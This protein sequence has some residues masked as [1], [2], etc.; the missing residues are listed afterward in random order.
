VFNEWS[1][2]FDASWEIDVWG[3]VRRGIQAAGAN[4]V[5][6]HRAP[7]NRI[8][9]LEGR[10]QLAGGEY[11][12]IDSP[13]RQLAD[14][15]GEPICRS[16]ESGKIRR[17]G[18]DHAPA[19]RLAR[20]LTGRR[21]AGWRAGRNRAQSAIEKPSSLHCVVPFDRWYSF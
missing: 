13:V 19:V 5:H 7:G 21:F 8:E 16:T 20:P 10:D 9:D 4:L 18:R 12:D 3:Q 1:A 2:G 11:L 6:L 17:P 14:S 15:L